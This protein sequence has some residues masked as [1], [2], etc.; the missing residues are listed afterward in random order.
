MVGFGCI[1]TSPKKSFV[2][3]IAEIH[4]ELVK[5]IKKY[6]PTRMAVE[7][8]FFLKCKTAIEVGRRAQF[9]LPA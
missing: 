3:R 2:E 9:C 4:D 6:K 7:E 8:L 5:I 1:E